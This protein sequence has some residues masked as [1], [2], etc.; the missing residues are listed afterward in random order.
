MG[1]LLEFRAKGKI[2][3]QAGHF[4]VLGSFDMRHDPKKEHSAFAV[5]IFIT[6]AEGVKIRGT[7]LALPSIF[8]TEIT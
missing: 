2:T 1:W 5:D 4:S 8:V 6:F 3:V 7:L